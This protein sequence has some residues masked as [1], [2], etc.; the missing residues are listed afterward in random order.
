[1]SKN[2]SH[3]PLL[4][5]FLGKVIKDSTPYVSAVFQKYNFDS[6]YYQL[7]DVADEAD[8]YFIPH[9]FWILKKSDRGL[10]DEF[11]KDA[12]KYK[13]PVLIDAYG[14]S[15]EKIDIPNGHILRTSQYKFKIKE[16]EIIMP[17]YTEDLLEAY[18]DNLFSL[19]EKKD[20]PSVGFVGYA[21]QPFAGRV[22][23]IVK[24]LPVIF[25]GLFL[26]NRETLRKGIFFR[27]K[28]IKYLTRSSVVKSNFTI[29]NFY[30]GHTETIRGD[31]RKIRQEFID[32]MRNS[33]YTLCVKGDGNF[34]YRFFEALSLG[35]IPLLVDTECAL[36]L[37]DIIDYKEFCVFVDYRDLSKIGEIL[38]KFH[39]NLDKEQFVMMQKKAR[40]VFENYFRI[41]SFTKHLVNQLKKKQRTAQTANKII[42]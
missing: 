11:L 4:F 25:I 38:R 16:N 41:D 24:E 35:R 34:S 13:K 7:A 28:A 8:F 10:L 14:D 27:K 3:S 9:N 21:N 36:P 20:I 17:P 42:E 30:S 2:L 23:A 29:R 33:D 1:M 12:K 19:R 31:S 22:K 40:E 37:E 26:K 5:P 18:F 32:N 39:D 15:D 6:K